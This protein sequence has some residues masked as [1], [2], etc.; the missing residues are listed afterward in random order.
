[1]PAPIGPLLGLALGAFFAWVLNDGAP[2]GKST[3]ALPPLAL[4]SLFGLLVFAPA[5]AY[6]IAFEPDWAYAYLVDG[7]RRLGAL[8][9]AVLLCDVVSLPLGFVLLVY[10]ARGPTF[11]QLLRL[12]G[13]PLLASGVFVVVLFP[14]LSVQATYAQ[15]HGDFGTRAVAGG[16]LGYALIW[17]TL[18]LSGAAAWT[19]HSLKRMR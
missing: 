17:T 3:L 5:A 4:V 2:R 10:S 15:F 18:V 11:A 9:A 19:A 12:L 16:P 6:F 7:S 1:M 8:H 13:A 14:R